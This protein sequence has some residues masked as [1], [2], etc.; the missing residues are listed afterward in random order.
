MALTKIPSSLLDTS[1][2]FDLQGN[3]TLGDNEKIILGTDSDLQIHHD[4]SNSIVSDEG[5]GQ[6]HL[7]G[8]GRVAILSSADDVTLANFDVGGAS[9][10]MYAGS[11]KL[12]TTSSGVDVTGTV[13][14]DGLTVD[15]DI[16]IASTVPR[17]I[18]SETDST[19][20][21]WDFR[22][23][24]GILKIRSLNDDL[25]TAQNRLEIGGN[26]DISFY[27]DTGSTA[28]FFWDASAESLGIG[29]TS[30]A[31]ELHV[32][33]S[34]TSSDTLT[35][36]N[37]TGNGSWRVKEGGS[38]NALLQGYNASNSETIRLDP[39]SDTFFNGGN[40]G[41][42][43]DSPDTQLNIKN[44]D[45]AVVRIESIGSESGDDA[46][47]ELKTT[48]GTF[49]IQNDRSLG[50]SG[51]LT[52]AGNTSDNIV[53]D[54]NNGLVGIGTTS[55]QTYLHIKTTSPTISMTDTNS[56]SDTNDRFQIRANADVGQF[57]WYDDSASST[58]TL[59]TI[60][61]S[62]YVEMASASQVRLT[63]GNSG[64]AGT[65]TANWVRGTGNELGFNSAGGG[66][67]WEIGGTERMRI[68][69]SGGLTF[70]GDTAAA[71]AL[72][73]Y[74]EGTFTPTLQ[75][76]TFTWSTQGGFYTKIGRMV[77]LNIFLKWTGKSGSGVV[78][79]SNFPFTSL[80]STS[81]RATGSLGYTSGLDFSTGT[82]AAYVAMSGN[83]TNAQIWLARDNL[84]PIS[85]DVSALSS[86]GE[87]QLTIT[88]IT[89]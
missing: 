72:D 81:Y 20:G 51:A 37:S 6:L 41:I 47:L 87:L 25:S 86:T 24:F 89:N 11:T 5:T 13:V 3:I 64:T 44:A 50:T 65:N 7:K 18:L 10:L 39:T 70:N 26:G 66:F 53:I 60:T 52:F 23:S 42:G 48:N 38:S 68:L 63:L 9:R 71:N 84:S 35:I 15:G 73:D 34:G 27:E 55:P 62:G 77:T 43:T 58:T 2:G 36:E 22:D 1:G 57:Q 46:R 16:T 67:H 40:F 45:D 78:A 12:A 33:S 54:H 31:S 30:P 83:D 69:A 49:T 19:N 85:S 75:N 29:T 76:G 8:N 56:F 82:D 32:K 21:N 59:M 61:P 28:K 74:E 88:Y 79:F 80:N 17:L 4:G 14:A